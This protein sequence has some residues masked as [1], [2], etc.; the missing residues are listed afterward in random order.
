V[1]NRVATVILSASVRGAE[2]RIGNKTL[3]NTKEGQTIL[4]VNAGPQTLTITNRISFRSSDRSRWR[5]AR[6]RRSTCDLRHEARR[7]FS[8]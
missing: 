6:S 7:R 4:R 8:A 3:G 1:R 5:P 2:I